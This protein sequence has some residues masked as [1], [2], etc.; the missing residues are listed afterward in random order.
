[1]HIS[2]TFHLLPRFAALCLLPIALA[3]ATSLA[4]AQPGPAVPAVDTPTTTAQLSKAYVRSLLAAA[5]EQPGADDEIRQ[6]QI[7]YYEQALEQLEQADQWSSQTREAETARVQAPVLAARLQQE[8]AQEIVD[9]NPNPPSGASLQQLEQFMAASQQEL[10][11]AQRLGSE[12]SAELKRRADRRIEI[13]RLASAARQRLE[14]L[15]T[16]EA[17]GPL[18]DEPAD[19]TASR[20]LL[21]KARRNALQQEL[22]TYEKELQSYD[23][24]SE[25]LT[26]RQDD[27]SRRVARLEKLVREWQRLVNEQRRGE[28]EQVAEEARKKRREAANS[29][30]AIQRL[31]EENAALAERRTGARG[32]S[33]RIEQVSHELD[34]TNSILASL[35][36][37]AQSLRSKVEAVGLS[38][39]IGI[40]LRK[41]REELKS[42]LQAA[43]RPEGRRTEIAETHLQLLELEDQL[44][45]LRDLDAAVQEVLSEADAG[46]SASLMSRSEL[47]ARTR[48]VLQERRSYLQSLIKEYN[49]L[50]S[51]LIELETQESQ[52]EEEALSHASYID[53]R[54]LWIPSS[55]PFTLAHLTKAAASFGAAA[56]SAQWGQA[57]KIFLSDLRKRPLVYFAGAIVP[58]AIWSSRRRL[59]GALEENCLKAGRSGSLS[60][61]SIVRAGAA[62]MLLAFPAAFAIWF[63]GWRLQTAG[64]E[65]GFVQAIAN[66]FMAVG[67]ALLALELVRVTSA[68]RGLAA[69]CFHWSPGALRTLRRNVLW[70]AVAVLPVRA[71]IEVAQWHGTEIRDES[72]A[73]ILFILGMFACAL[74]GHKVLH[75]SH[76]VLAGTIAKDHG[77]WLMRLRFFW[78]AVGVVTPLLLAVSAFL[79]Y[80]YTAIHLGSR[81][82]TTVWLCIGLAGI[83]AVLVHWLVISRRKLALQ[84]ARKRWNAETQEEETGEMPVALE[85]PALDVSRAAVQANRF[86]RSTMAF[87]FGIG[88]W[89]IW[90]D[91]LPALG[92]LRGYELWSRQVQTAESVAGPNGLQVQQVLS[93]VEPVTLAD[94]LFALVVGLMTVVAAR[95]L[96]GILEITV[97]QRLKLDNGAKYAAATI[98]RYLI[99]LAGAIVVLRAIGVGWNNVQWMAAAITVGLGFG[100]QEIFANFISGLILLFER[101]IRA[102]DIV[103]VNGILGKVGRIQ[104]RAT[105][106][107]DMDHKELIIPNKEFI[108]G[109]VINYT[110]TDTVIRLTVTVGVAY[111]SDYDEARRILLHLASEHPII[112]AD[113]AP[114]AALAEFKESS[115]EFLLFVHL[116]DLNNF[117][118]VRHDLIAGIEREFTR[119][120]IQIPFPQRD[121]YVRGL[122][123]KL[124][125]ALS[126]QEQMVPGEAP[127][128]LP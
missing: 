51:R 3:A 62:T 84:E 49:S 7:A 80:Q 26:L 64:A 89:L 124:T 13:P 18:P 15:K 33:S 92:I 52:L 65:S 47:E 6:K 115:V 118:A 110:L 41:Q 54:I 40:L 37:Q 66:G 96:P 44:A 70:L 11:D 83:N 56:T 57:W 32:L 119:A 74:F 93:K 2:P 35:R 48:E 109:Q 73:R 112:L 1:M 99:S 120:G 20:M 68:E 63:L 71:L 67:A 21:V 91:V 53:E 34:E 121:L 75:S 102:G 30:P 98:A 61:Y 43:R 126:R 28:A 31:T 10:A 76:G 82:L 125:G 4:T 114:I 104:I 60:F 90:V 39:T 5:K 19:L 22:E 123:E 23:A 108:T 45:D 36:E 95:N 128:G 100:L 69:N 24:R 101:P 12:L 94:A 72:F 122:D 87:T 107:V 29:H 8:L 127:A 55:P 88:L 38:D 78:Y 81:L 111:G 42:V 14:E 79:G 103:M 97:L 25:L 113:P 59:W 16:E 106:I 77:G 116:P 117:L 58:L 9:T 17:A 50:F 105:T 86:L 27:A 46:N 85:E